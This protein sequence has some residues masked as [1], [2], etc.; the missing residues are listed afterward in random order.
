MVL[1][2]GAATFEEKSSSLQTPQCPAWKDFEK[3]LQ[4]TRERQLEGLKRKDLTTSKH[5]DDYWNP[6]TF[7]AQANIPVTPTSTSKPPSSSRRQEKTADGT[8]SKK[9]NN[10][11]IDLTTPMVMAVI[12][13]ASVGF[14]RLEVVEAQGSGFQQLAGSIALE[15]FNSSE[16]QIV[17]AGVTLFII[18]MGVQLMVD[19]ATFFYSKHF[20]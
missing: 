19:S 9:Q 18:G 20:V 12:L 3:L 13:A 1:A 6:I 8:T 17:L 10:S 11:T 5:K 16:L 2:T 15:V 4:D 7:L 14:R